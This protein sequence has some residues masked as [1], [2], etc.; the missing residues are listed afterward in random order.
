VRADGRRGAD[1]VRVRVRVG[2]RVRVRVNV[3]VSVGVRARVRVG[4]RV[5]VR[6]RVRVGQ[7]SPPP[8]TATASVYWITSPSISTI[9]GRPQR[10]RASPVAGGAYRPRASSPCARM[11][12]GVPPAVGP[13]V[14]SIW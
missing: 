1:L 5:R 9:H 12:T 7:T 8:S 14:G 11:V 4:V 6:V 10:Q 13:P 3:G 2:V